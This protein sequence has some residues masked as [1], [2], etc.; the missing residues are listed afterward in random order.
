[1]GTIY[2]ITNTMNNKCYIGQT[3]RDVK[4]RVHE[5]LFYESRGNSAIKRAI[6]KYGHSN[7]TYEILHDSILEFMLDDLEKEEIKKHNS[8]SP[9]GYNL[10]TGG[11]KNKTFSKESIEKMS[12][13]QNMRSPESRRRQADTIRG[14]PCPKHVKQLSDFLK[15]NQHGRGHTPPNKGIPM[16]PE[17]KRKISISKKGKSNIKKRHPDREKSHELFDSLPSSMSITEKRKIISKAFPE[18]NYKTIWRW[19][20][21][22]N[23]Q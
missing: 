6:K 8:L 3:I 16:S 2:K 19:T 1:M 23:N 10:A 5:H 17:Q 12:K 11:N 18:R 4:R 9:N 20:R 22:W 7:F 21:L 13:S 15:G 14:R